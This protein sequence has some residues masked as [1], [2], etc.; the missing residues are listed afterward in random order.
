M[1]GPPLL[2]HIIGLKNTGKSGLV[3]SLVRE[4]TERG[5]KTGVL[6]HDGAGHFHWDREGT[7]TYRMRQAGS[8]V[9]AILSDREFA[10]HAAGGLDVTL[11]EI[12]ETFFRGFDIVL[13]EGFKKLEGKKIEVLRKVASTHPLSPEDEL[14]ATFGD[15]LF[16]RNVP[17]FDGTSV[18]DLAGLISRLLPAAGAATSR[19]GPEG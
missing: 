8:P 5:I 15:R 10:V 19:T 16:D 9:T 12:V 18:P 11:P 4:L 13:V 1:A 2:I 14:I 3:E 7:D 6:K 17:H